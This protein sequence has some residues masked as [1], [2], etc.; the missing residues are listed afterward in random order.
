MVKKSDSLIS[1]SAGDGANALPDPPAIDPEDQK[2][3]KAHDIVTGNCKWAAG[4]G[5]VP[6]PVADWIAVTTIQIKML[7]QLCELYD[8]PFSQDQAAK[9]IFALTGGFIPATLGFFAASVVK[10]I[11][12][13]GV[14]RFA[15]VP[16]FAY[17]TTY[18]LGQVFIPYF[19]SGGSLYTFDPSKHKTYFAYLAEEGKRAAASVIG[20][21]A[22]HEQAPS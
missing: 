4:L 3:L 18:A 12:F 19:Q 11:P 16:A 10:T 21:A 7:K 20:K 14:A 15:A 8:K 1:E 5:F 13:V 6:I 9:W 2:L 22:P 17:G